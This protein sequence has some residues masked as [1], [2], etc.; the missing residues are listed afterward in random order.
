MTREEKIALVDNPNLLIKLVSKEYSLKTNSFDKKKIEEDASKEAKKKTY[1]NLRK[2]LKDSKNL[3]SNAKFNFKRKADDTD[4]LED[5]GDP[6]K[7]MIGKIIQR[8]LNR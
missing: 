7:D 2:L 8:N 5:T 3:G 6:T 1:E 4:G